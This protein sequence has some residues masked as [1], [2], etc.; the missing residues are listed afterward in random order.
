MK[1]DRPSW[2]WRQEVEA[3]KVELECTKSGMASEY[4]MDLNDQ[5]RKRKAVEQQLATVTQERD[6]I[7]EI[8]EAVTEEVI[9]YANISTPSGKP[10]EPSLPESIRQMKQDLHRQLAEITQERDEAVAVARSLV[11]CGPI[12]QED[13]DWA[14]NALNGGLKKEAR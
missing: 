8:C 12:T 1:E 3:L 2:E 4:E 14:A 5:I 11:A 10:A 7:R 9:E 6:R 13:I